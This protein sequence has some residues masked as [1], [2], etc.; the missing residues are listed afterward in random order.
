MKASPNASL[1]EIFSSI[2]GEGVHIGR[3]QVFIRTS[4]CNLNCSYCD[5]PKS[6]DTNL[7]K[8]ELSLGQGVV[9]F[10][11]NPTPAEVAIKAVLSLEK[12]NGPHH[13]V[14]LTGGEPLLHVDFVRELSKELKSAGLNVHLETNAT[15]LDELLDVLPYISHISAD[16]KL[17]SVSGLESSKSNLHLS[18]IKAGVA[19]QKDLCVKIIVSKE[20]EKS[21]IEEAAKRI[22]EIA[23]SIPLIIQPISKT[24]GVNQNLPTGEQLLEWQRNCLKHLVDVRVIPQCHRIMG[25]P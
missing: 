20:T 8:W 9:Q 2:Q 6:K 3:R 1:V 13:S 7:P 24:S 11:P 17:Q 14:V 12:Q 22:S 16:Y 5:T 4:G 25:L 18:F 15:M 19:S 10:L 23:Y 21:E